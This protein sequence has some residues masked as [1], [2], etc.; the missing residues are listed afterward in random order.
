ML[1][2]SAPDN[3]A[4]GC[5]N[6]SPRTRVTAPAAAM[7]YTQKFMV[8]PDSSLF[9]SPNNLAI[10]LLPPIPK[11]QAMDMIISRIGAHKVTAAIIAGSFVKD[12]KNVSAILYIS[13]VSCPSIAGSPTLIIALELFFSSK[14]DVIF[15]FPPLKFH[16]L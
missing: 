9:S 6:V 15:S 8:V 12:T 2:A 16:L 11:M 7:E 1:S 5:K 4:N 3:F 10:T 14:T 13:V